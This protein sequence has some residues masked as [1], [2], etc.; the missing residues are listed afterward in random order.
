MIARRATAAGLAAAALFGASTPAAKLLV[1]GTGTLMLAGLLYVGASCT[2]TCAWRARRTIVEHE[3]AHVHDDHYGGVPSPP[4]LM[5]MLPIPRDLVTRNFRR[6]I[7][8]PLRFGSVGSRCPGP[9]S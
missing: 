2:C 9:M 1:P 7:M 4:Q 6:F 5:A 3:H 8:T